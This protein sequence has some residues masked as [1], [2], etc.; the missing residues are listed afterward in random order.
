MLPN[1][2]LLRDNRTEVRSMIGYFGDP[3]G[4]HTLTF[5]IEFTDENGDTFV[6]PAIVLTKG[7]TSVD[8]QYNVDQFRC[9]NNPCT[10]SYD[11][12]LFVD[13]QAVC[14]QIAFGTIAEL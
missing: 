3:D 7:R 12:S 5:V 1:R 11:L 6:N 4:G 13:G 2:K 10:D 9:N 14:S 8:V